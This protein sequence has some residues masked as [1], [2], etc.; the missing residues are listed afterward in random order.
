[1]T[2]LFA[3]CEFY[4]HGPIQLQDPL[5]ERPELE[6]SLFSGGSSEGETPVPIPNTEVKPLSVDGTAPATGWES[7]SPPGIDLKKAPAMGPFSFGATAEPVDRGSSERP[8]G[9]APS[10]SAEWEPVA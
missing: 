2:N 3:F 1:M 4:R 7:R 8:E 10:R 5:V 9:E 6:K